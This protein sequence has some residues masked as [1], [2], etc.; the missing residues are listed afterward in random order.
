[1]IRILNIAAL[2]GY[3][4]TSVA[5]WWTP[6]GGGFP[7]PGGPATIYGDAQLN[8]LLVGGS[9][10]YA[11]NGSDSVT[12]VGIGAWDGWQWDSL[13]T[14]VQPWDGP[15]SN[16]CAN[17]HSFQRINGTLYANGGWGFP[18]PDST[19][20]RRIARLNEDS[21]RWEA[22]ECPNPLVGG[23]M[24]LLRVAGDTSF[25][26]G[27]QG[28]ICG[29][30]PSCVFSYANGTIQR[31][32]PFDDWP[33][34]S[35]NYVGYV[36]PFQGQ[37]YMTGLVNDTANSAYYGFL[38]YTGTEWEPVPGFETY[39][40]IK[41]VL[42]HDNKLFV[43][44]YFFEANGQPG[45][46]VASFDGSQWDNLGGGLLYSLTSPTSGNPTAVDMFFD[47]DTLYVAGQFKFAGG[48]PAQNIAKWNGVQ[49]CSF[50]GVFDSYGTL[51]A[52][53]WNNELYVV[54]GFA[55]IDG[56]LMNQVA[57]YN[58]GYQVLDCS[59]PIS[60]PESVSEE[61]ILS[62][63]YN[64][65]TASVTVSTLPSATHAPVHLQL[66]DPLGRQVLTRRVEL[67]EAVSVAALASGAYLARMI[68]G[69]NAMVVG[70]FVK[71]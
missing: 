15:P 25:I 64:A 6:L 7:P 42:I 26:T 53:M 17:T 55:A 11:L 38:R 35:S 56:V 63:L 24:H 67:N 50:P 32:A 23:M 45:N 8:K 47:A 21:S 33:E 68:T 40:P 20:N 66:F 34:H 69:P 14:R 36:F 71:H 58:G 46:L 51:H 39:G 27:W 37:Y 30:A 13:A 16:V 10:P 31:W 18:T 65:A 48:I 54:G 22:L 1:M 70:R 9:F 2:V 29:E 52:A 12:I 28:T 62:I 60:I 4:L 19:W 61:P 59:S 57:R 5:Q 49:W 43:C 44:G 3:S 41:K